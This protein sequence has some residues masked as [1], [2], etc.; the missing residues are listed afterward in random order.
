MLTLF[1]DGRRLS[2]GE[3]KCLKSKRETRGNQAQGGRALSSQP[4]FHAQFPV[5]KQEYAEFGQ[6]PYVWLIK[7]HLICLAVI[8]LSFLM[9]AITEQNY[10]Y[11][12]CVSGASALLCGSYDIRRSAAAALAYRRHMIS[13]GKPGTIYFLN[14]C[15]YLVSATDT[16]TPVSYDYK[17]IVSI[18]ESER[19]FLLFLPYRLYI[20]VEKAAKCG[21]SREEFL[22]Y[23]FSKCPRCRSTVQK[24]KYK[25]QICLA[26][27]ILFPGSIPSRVCLVCFRFR[28]ESRRLSKGRN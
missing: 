17:S 20:P 21:G 7:F 28:K 25:R 15:G 10:L 26:L 8:L 11:C 2:E 1:F 13:E 9:Q 18:A 27:A 3:S 19:F 6:A 22:S 5:G 24:V 4:V 12:A 14:F 23:L 16:H